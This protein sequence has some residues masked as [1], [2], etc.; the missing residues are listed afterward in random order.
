MKLLD[1]PIIKLTCCILFGILIACYITIPTV[2]SAIL[3]LIGFLTILFGYLFKSLGRSYWFGICVF[4]TGI[5][6]GILTYN[7]HDQK[8]WKA[9]YNNIGINQNDVSLI[10]FKITKRLKPSHFH[11]KYE[12]KILKIN[13][14]KVVGKILVNI[15]K[16]STESYLYV[17][18]AYVINSKLST[19]SGPKNPFQFNY[20][21]YLKKRHIYAQLFT[22]SE[23][24]VKLKSIRTSVHAYAEGLRN[25]I[26]HNLKNS[27]L[28]EDELSI[29]QALLLGQRQDIS[30]DIYDDYAKAGVIH[31]LA[32]S[33]LHVGIIMLILQFLFKPLHRIKYGR[34]IALICITIFLWSFAV[35]A[36]LSPS[37]CR[38]VTMF[39]IVAFALNIK[40]FT[41][42][43]NTLAISA[44]VLLLW[45]PMFVFDVGFQLS[46]IAVIA[47]VSIQPLLFKLWIPKW[48]IPRKL[49]EVFTVTT[50]AQLG[51]LPLSLFYFHQFPGLFFL[52]NLVIIPFLGILLGTG[53]V[54]ILL[55][56]FNVLPDLISE[57]F[58]TAIYLLNTFIAWV[59]ERE[60]FLFTE[61]SFGILQV[62]ACYVLLRLLYKYYINKTYKNLRYALFAVVLLQ[63][64]FIYYTWQR[65]DDLLIVFNKNRASLLGVQN[66]S[67]LDLYSN[68]ESLQNDYI[69]SNYKI[70]NRIRE[71][72]SKPLKSVF[73]YKDKTILIIDSLAVYNV[74]S[75]KP[76]VILL[77][78][79]PKL[80][81]NRLLDSLKP[82]HVIADA[83][84]YKSYVERWKVTCENKKTPFHSTYE[85]GAFML[86][87]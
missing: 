35:I 57:V 10:T 11:N 85:K 68:L 17:D 56:Y 50:A 9:H 27:R 23:Q 34:Y 81:L 16:D 46:Y 78:N 18:E 79:S 28:S 37:V 59:S 43:Y 26:I 48:V 6:I 72:T 58:G 3:A 31:I 22:T 49:W 41:N 67:K 44:F 80:N 71:I 36:G 40:R 77:T 12:A 47:I 15:S 74:S 38:A 70:G 51:V 33:G 39:T 1:F 19:I 60:S 86:S 14:E 20:S 8:R 63:L 54:I 66:N 29:I 4:I 53:L 32:V 64:S 76:D 5:S 13:N 45:N 73:K 65:N 87:E 55:A 69:L 62:M 61:I 52:S 83:S 42:I 75:F 25:K 24:L 21:D 84:N 30:K 7:L 2:T 82:Q